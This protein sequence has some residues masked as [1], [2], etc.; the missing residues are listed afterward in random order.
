M[1]YSP[2]P[3]PDPFDS[4]EAKAGPAP[5]QEGNQT[6]PG[7]SVTQW[8]GVLSNHGGGPLS[9]ELALDL[10][11]N[12]IV[13]RACAATG[14]DAAA[15]ALERDGEFVCRATTGESAPGL[16]A[17]LSTDSGLSAACVKT[18][19]WQC[20]NDTEADLRVNPEV[21]RHLGVRSILVLPILRED[22]L[23]GII[24]VFSA[25]PSAFGDVEAQSLQRFCRDI[26]ASIDLAAGANAPVEAPPATTD[27]PP[28]EQPL[29]PP[30]L[31]VAAPGAAQRRLQAS[32]F[33]TG[34]LLLAVVVLALILGW[35]VGRA[36][37]RRATTESAMKAQSLQEQPG[38][39]PASDSRPEAKAASPKGNATTGSGLVVYKEGKVVFQLPPDSTSQPA[40][41][42][43]A[44]PPAP[45]QN[46]PAGPRI[47]IAP[48]IA[49]GYLVQRIEPD[50]PLAAR[51]AHIQGDVVLDAMVGDDG[52]VQKLRPLNGDPQLVTAAMDAVQHWRFRPFFRN[53]RP[54]AFE[55]QIT[56]M[57]RLP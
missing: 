30:H 49:A 28:E 1:A 46:V 36:G 42:P 21:C 38:A 33:W 39:L 52:N 7:L 29:P 47:R 11:L 10:V 4:R 57:F 24:E 6:E 51:Q 9:T 2:V 35:T 23:L 41:P 8:A 27:A 26:V 5:V 15:I 53:G 14:A 20:C 50:Y 3:R 18:R 17:R 22:T 32:D 45:A 43:V 56:V 34:V 12:E 37:R 19:H 31:Q 13:Q 16:G 48:Q 25:Q 54:E 40:N 44:T 55:T